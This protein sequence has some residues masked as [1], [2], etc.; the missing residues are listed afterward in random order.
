MNDKKTTTQPMSDQEILD[1]LAREGQDATI[2]P[3]ILAWIKRQPRIPP[4]QTGR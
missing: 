1:H 2:T 4:Q 3:E